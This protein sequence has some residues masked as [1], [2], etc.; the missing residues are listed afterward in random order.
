MIKTMFKKLF[1]KKARVSRHT[2]EEVK[3]DQ[4]QEVPAAKDDDAI[5]KQ[6]ED[7][8]EAITPIIDWKVVFLICGKCNRI[9]V[10]DGWQ[11][12][13]Y[14]H[15]CD[16]GNKKVT[17]VMYPYTRYAYRPDELVRKSEE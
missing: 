7:S 5:G 9:M 1:G 17:K 13:G 2:P 6:D 10:F 11:D 8:Y 15:V 3:P 4:K 12:G 16:C 14:R